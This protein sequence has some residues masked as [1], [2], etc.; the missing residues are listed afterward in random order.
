MWPHIYTLGVHPRLQVI[1][2]LGIFA[3]PPW[4]QF[5][6]TLFFLFR[7]PS[8]NQDTA[9]TPRLDFH[10]YFFYNTRYCEKNWFGFSATQITTGNLVLLLPTTRLTVGTWFSNFFDFFIYFPHKLKLISFEMHFKVSFKSYL[11]LYIF[12]FLATTPTTMMPTNLQPEVNVTTVTN[13]DDDSLLEDIR[14]LSFTDTTT[15]SPATARS[16]FANIGSLFKKPPPSLVPVPINTAPT[17]GIPPPSMKT[18]YV[19][20]PPLLAPDFTSLPRLHTT[21]Y[22]PVPA[23]VKSTGLFSGTHPSRVTFAPPVISCHST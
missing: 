23:P 12:L 16:F 22:A 10:G 5:I 3:V 6:Y 14:L 19:K 7:S 15:P 2:I 1:Y 17:S 20:T 9:L 11:V 8:L 21:A 4:L 18:M 13:D